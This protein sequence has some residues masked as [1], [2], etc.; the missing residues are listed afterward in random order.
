MFDIDV[1][2]QW[3]LYVLTPTTLVAKRWMKKHIPKPTS[4]GHGVLCCEGSDRCQDIVAG[5]VKD[6]LTVSVNGV[7]MKGFAFAERTERSEES[8]PG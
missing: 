2:G 8:G 1:T 4:Y 7:D 3:G 5:A 6:G